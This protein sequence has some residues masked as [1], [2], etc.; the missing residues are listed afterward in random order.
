MDANVLT[1][2]GRLRGVVSGM[3]FCSHGPS[4]RMRVLVWRILKQNR[5]IF[6]DGERKTTRFDVGDI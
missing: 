1:D 2:A 5:V 4:L 3:L 6:R